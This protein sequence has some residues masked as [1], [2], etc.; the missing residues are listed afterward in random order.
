MRMNPYERQLSDYENEELI[1]EME[2]RQL[3]A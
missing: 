3:L 1:L 2:Q